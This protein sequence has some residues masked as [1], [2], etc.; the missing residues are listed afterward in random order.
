MRWLPGKRGSSNT[1]RLC[2]LMDFDPERVTALAK[3]YALAQ[4]NCGVAPPRRVTFISPE[5]DDF[6]RGR[7]VE[8]ETNALADLFR[9][10]YVTEDNGYLVQNPEVDAITPRYWGKTDSGWSV[11][12]EAFTL[13]RRR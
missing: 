6:I 2:W 7:L 13:R 5:G 8:I 1:T 10:R 3:D 9:L 4:N 12:P 11:W